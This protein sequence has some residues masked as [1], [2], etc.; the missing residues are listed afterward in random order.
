MLLPGFANT[1]IC[2]KL[3]GY[4]IEITKCLK[5]LYFKFS[6]NYRDIVKSTRTASCDFTRMLI[7]RINL[8]ISIHVL[9][10]V[11]IKHND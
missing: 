6:E 7:F 11:L 8:V 5:F 2:I 4:K 10:Y 3:Q 1:L 9:V